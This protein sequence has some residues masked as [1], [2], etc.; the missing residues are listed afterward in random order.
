MRSSIKRHPFRGL[1][2]AVLGLLAAYSMFGVFTAVSM[3]PINPIMRLSLLY[4]PHRFLPALSWHVEDHVINAV[5]FGVPV[6]AK[7]LMGINR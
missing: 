6:L 2:W 4:F 5:L 3:R 7:L 1:I